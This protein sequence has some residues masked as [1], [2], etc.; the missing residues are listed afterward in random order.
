MKDF[1]E[2]SMLWHQAPIITHLENLT[3]ISRKIDSNSNILRR[4]LEEDWQDEK[5][6]LMKETD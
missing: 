3:K 4:E 6:I 5:S 2:M 1:Q